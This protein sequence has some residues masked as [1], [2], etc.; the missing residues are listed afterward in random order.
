M[1]KTFA[2]EQ[3]LAH[4]IVISHLH[5]QEKRK[6]LGQ[7]VSARTTLHGDALQL[8]ASAEPLLTKKPTLKWVP[9]RGC[10]IIPELTTRPYGVPFSDVPDL[11]AL[12]DTINASNGLNTYR[13]N[14]EDRAAY[15]G[16]PK[17]TLLRLDHSLI[18]K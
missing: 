1:N 7:P 2:V 12:C 9:G 6:S 18:G 4:E 11:E 13:L 17:A 5:E 10:W 8:I 16:I 14:P 3:A 15:A